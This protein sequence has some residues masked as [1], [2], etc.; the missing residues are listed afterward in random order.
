MRRLK[1]L[2]WNENEHERTRPEVAAIYPLGIHGTL[3]GGLA[4]D[5]LHISV[6]TMDMPQQGLP[7]GALNDVDVLV[8]WGHILHDRV[9][10]RIVEAIITRV[11][12]GMGFVALHS[13]HHSLAFQRL[14]GTSCNL[15]W[16]DSESGE[17]VRLWCVLPS[18]PIARGVAMHIEIPAD[19]MYGEPFNVPRPDDVV[20]INW[21]QGGEVFRGGCTWTRGRGRIFHFSPGHETYPVF[22]QAEVLKVIG[23]GVRWAA[24]THSDGHDMSNL[25]RPV[26]PETLRLSQGFDRA[27]AAQV[28][29]ASSCSN[30]HTGTA[31]GNTASS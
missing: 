18:H 1:V 11:N 29:S 15:A 7:S 22:H 26:S 6:A 10:Q 24:E 5:D 3:A 17:R 20:F 27:E 12:A 4:A 25:H 21:Y 16:R 23:N 31:S 9:E 14:M 30:M 2:I 13:A 19:E 8:W 28:A